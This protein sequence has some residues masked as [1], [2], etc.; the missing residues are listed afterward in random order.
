MGALRAPRLTLPLPPD[1]PMRPPLLLP[2]HHHHRRRPPNL[3]KPAEAQALADAGSLGGS[4]TAAA[5]A[6]AEAATKCAPA[7]PAPAV[8]APAP[9]VPAPA[10]VVAPAPAPAVAPAPAP[11]VVP[12][13]APV[14][15]A[16]AP[17][18]PVAS[19]AAAPAPAAAATYST[20]FGLAASDCCKKALPVGGQC[21]CAGGGSA[22]ACLF[23]VQATAPVKLI[24][25][26]SLSSMAC[27]CPAA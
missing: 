25:M 1:A 3:P 9:A 11:A 24:K 5:L 22:G 2:H 19:T 21:G 17:E 4:A 12:V 18:V 26:G 10:P 15:A 27:A 16:P 7:A 23:R 20:C 14:V 8:P 13:P 6:A